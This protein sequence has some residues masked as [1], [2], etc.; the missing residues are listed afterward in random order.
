MNH[1]IISLAKIFEQ[2][3]KSCNHLI[4]KSLKIIDELLPNLKKSGRASL[5]VGILRKLFL[6]PYISS[7]ELSE[8]F[9]VSKEDLLEIFYLMKSSKEIRNLFEFSPYRYL[10]EVLEDL[11]KNSALTLKI[12]KKETSFPL[13]KTMELFISESCNAKCKFCYREGKL[14]DG[15]KKVNSA[16]AYESNR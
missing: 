14:Y 10:I 15:E 2:N 5:F 7:K 3:S 4:N 13:S 11:S 9:N 12:L 8:E 16:C 1:L 6:T